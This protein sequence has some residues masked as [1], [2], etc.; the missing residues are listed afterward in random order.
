MLGG[1]LCK[2]L[3]NRRARAG[4]MGLPQPDLIGFS[5]HDA[6][7]LWQE[8]QLRAT[9]CRLSNPM[10]HALEILLHAWSAHHLYR[11]HFRHISSPLSMRTHPGP[12]AYFALISGVFERSSRRADSTTGSSQLPVTRYS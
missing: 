4:P 8:H 11:S 12:L 1:R 3:L 2:G 10:P 6:K 5:A 7:I 9:G